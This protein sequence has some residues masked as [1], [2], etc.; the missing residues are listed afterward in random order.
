MCSGLVIW[1]PAA[2][3]RRAQHT[4]MATNG[5]IISPA[6][7]CTSA[8]MNCG[9]QLVGFFFLLGEAC[10]IV[11]ATSKQRIEFR[12]RPPLLLLRI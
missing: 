10:D 7:R 1:T 5:I 11:S 2:A 3:Q 8:A 6:Q 4:R 9:Q 12:E